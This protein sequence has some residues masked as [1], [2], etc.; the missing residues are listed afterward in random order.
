MERNITLGG[1][2]VFVNVTNL[3]PGTEYVFRVVAMASDGQ[4]S[5]RSNALVTTTHELRVLGMYS[6][7]YSA[8]PPVYT[9]QPPVLMHI[10]T[11]VVLLYL[12]SYSA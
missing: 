11:I 9:L 8:S 1:E 3:L 4:T 5:P 2:E 10:F 7:L 6:A 12:Y